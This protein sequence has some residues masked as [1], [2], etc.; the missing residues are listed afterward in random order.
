MHSTTGGR[1]LSPKSY[2]DVPAGPW[3]SDFLYTTFLP[4]FP[5]TRI[6][7]LKGKHPILTK[8]GAFYNNL[9]KIH[10]I[11]VIWA[12]SSLMKPSDH[13][14]KFC[15]KRQAHTRIPCQCENPPVQ[16]LENICTRQLVFH[17]IQKIHTK[18]LNNCDST[19]H[20]DYISGASFALHCVQTFTSHMTQRLS[21]CKL[22]SYDDMW[23][24]GMHHRSNHVYYELCVSLVT[25]L[26]NK[27]IYSPYLYDLQYTNIYCNERPWLKLLAHGDCNCAIL[28]LQSPRDNSFN[29]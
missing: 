9:P 4:N 8:L 5:P 21:P 12:P 3:K 13:Y 18:N 6:P 19:L 25:V 10:P 17:H 11:Y 22:Q 15:S 27:L 28:Q 16:L 7:F 1:V 23:Y 24:K 2:M 14:T 26:L 20:T 29:P